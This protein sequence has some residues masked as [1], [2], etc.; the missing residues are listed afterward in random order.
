[1]T[2]SCVSILIRSI[3]YVAFPAP[4]LPLDYRQASR[5]RVRRMQRPYPATSRVTA[6]NVVEAPPTD[7]KPAT[8]TVGCRP[9]ATR[10]TPDLTTAL[11]TRRTNRA[12]AA[13]RSVHAAAATNRAG[14]ATTRAPVI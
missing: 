8:T 6:T 1:M 5:A 13:H 11:A 9:Q 10:S 7:L 12:I 3:A 14:R 2:R 4:A